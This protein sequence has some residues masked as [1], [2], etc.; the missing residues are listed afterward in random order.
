M[1]DHTDGST[2]LGQA[3][4]TEKAS[5]TSADYEDIDPFQNNLLLRKSGR[6]VFIPPCWRQAEAV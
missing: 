2:P 5:R 1:I 4:A 3:C 6:K